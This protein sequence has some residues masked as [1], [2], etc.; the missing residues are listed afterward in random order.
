MHLENVSNLTLFTGQSSRFCG[1]CGWRTSAVPP[2]SGSCCQGTLSPPQLALSHR[3]DTDFV[4][5]LFPS[6][7][8]YSATQFKAQIAAEQ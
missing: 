6:Y 5:F 2:R 1:V 4:Q 7:S 3:A 8:R